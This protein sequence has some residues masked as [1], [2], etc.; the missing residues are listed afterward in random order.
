MKKVFV[1]LMCIVSVLSFAFMLSSC[2][3]HEHKGEKWGGDKTHH[4]HICDICQSAFETAEHNFEE[5]QDGGS[6][7][8]VCQICQYSYTEVEVAE[9]D[10]TFAESLSYNEAFHFKS[11]TFEGCTAESEKVEHLYDTPEIVQETGKITKTYPCQNC[12][13][14]KTEIITI[15]TVIKDSSAWNLA[16]ENLELKNFEMRVSFVQNGE[17]AFTNYCIITD[18][19]AYVSYGDGAR[20]VYSKKKSNGEYEVYEKETEE[21]GG[22]GQWLLYDDKDGK[23]YSSFVRE[24][25]LGIT[26]TENYSKFTYNE[27]TGEYTC[28]ENIECTAYSFDG[29]V[30]PN[31]M[32]CFN[33]VV[34]V[35]DGKISHIECDYYFEGAE[36]PENSSQSFIYYN[37]GIAEFEIPESVKEAAIHRGDYVANGAVSESV[38]NEN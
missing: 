24:A 36:M 28:S 37:I 29:S 22:S 26:Y 10:H 8:K 32:Y 23:F 13:Y 14:K 9:H 33:N 5:T 27:E 20:E 3:E 31:K 34:K 4:W 19:G 30:Y 21:Y 1:Y 11:C 35:A 15:D 38:P 25:V 17:V 6:I 16:F 2:D 7:V 18:D 12:E